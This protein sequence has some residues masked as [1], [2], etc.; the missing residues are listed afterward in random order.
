MKAVPILVIV[1]TALFGLGLGVVASAGIW[2]VDG[3]SAA[4]GRGAG[5]SA[6]EPSAGA[7]ASAGPA[8]TAS[9]GARPAVETRAFCQQ[10]VPAAYGPTVWPASE[11]SAPAPASIIANWG[12]G[13][14]G[15][16]GGPGRSRS[17]ARLTMI[18]QARAKGIQVLGYV[19]TDYANNAAGHPASPGMTQ[20]PLAAVKKE[21]MEWFNWYGVTGLFFD[22]ATTG[23]GNGQLRYY[24]HL[25]K[26]VHAHIPG[27]QVW[28]NPG[29][30]PHPSYMSAADVIMDFESSYGT[31]AA[32]PPPA[33]VH[34]YPPRRFA[35]VLHLPDREASSLGAALALTQ[36]DNA[37]HV[38][39]ADQQNYSA[40]PAYWTAETAG[41]TARCG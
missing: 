2:R 9:T 7:S 24:R 5:T 26:Y 27:A 11:S 3:V 30:Y 16:G 31:L 6:A 35:N 22:G 21:A 15:A 32:N 25:Y 28:I 33:W 8:A 14:G 17:A 36:A 1:L 18:R 10:L 4:A 37:G 38:Y 13:Y 39:V 12:Q 23:T 20:A 29:W 19:W 40:L 41:V 34:R